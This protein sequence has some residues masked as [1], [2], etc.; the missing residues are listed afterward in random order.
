MDMMVAPVQGHTDAAWRH[1]YS[2]I[3]GGDACFFTPFIRVEQGTLRKHDM[4]DLMSGLNSGMQVIP[5]VIFRD[6]DE[7]RILVDA[8]VENGVGKINLNSGCPFPL[9]TAKGRGAAF[10]SN[11]EEYS[12]LRE[13]ISRY[14][15]VEFS[16]KMR[17]G[18]SDSTEWENVI[19]ILNDMRLAHIT[20]HPRVAKQQY[21]GEVDL[22][23]FAL[24]LER[25][26]NPVVYNGDLNT[27]EQIDDV[28]RKFP[29]IAG[30]MVGRGLL[31]RPSLISEYRSGKEWDK[32]E[33][34][35]RMRNFHDQ[36]LDHYQTYL[37]GDAQVLSK[38]KP[39]WEYSEEEIG[40]KPW[41]AI[42][43]ATTMAKYHT[44]VAQIL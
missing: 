18:L 24:F 43:K 30:I 19:S 42:K 26:K 4:K 31:G 10:I 20:L 15:E 32:T 2:N 11:V 37:C 36:L 35:N 22:T 1:F 38:I 39:F 29:T 25:S 16:V 21:K 27:P 44:A 5:Q 17:L 23:Q 14:P 41:K 3:Y 9:Q 7:L 40:R 8:L 28:I 33:R 13:F 34:L 6:M 12:K